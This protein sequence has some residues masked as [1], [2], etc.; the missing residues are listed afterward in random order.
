MDIYHIN[1]FVTV[2]LMYTVALLMAYNELCKSKI[3]LFIVNIDRFIN[4]YR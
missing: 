2:R 3:H 4:M 1:G